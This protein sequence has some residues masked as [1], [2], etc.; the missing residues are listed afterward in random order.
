MFKATLRFGLLAA[1][2]ISARADSTSYSRRPSTFLIPGTDHP[3]ND[4][5]TVFSAGTLPF[6]DTYVAFGGAQKLPR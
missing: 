1:L 4:Q 6:A 5:S 2:D 3:L